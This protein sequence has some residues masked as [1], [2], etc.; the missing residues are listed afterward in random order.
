[1][2]T[3]QAL[4]NT[5]QQKRPP[6]SSALKWAASVRRCGQIYQIHPSQESVTIS[7]LWQ[8]ETSLGKAG[9]T[10][11]NILLCGIDWWSIAN[12]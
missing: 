3:G 4:V 11:V 12:I 8:V 2:G 10:L 9:R 7:G 1:M 5:R 6:V